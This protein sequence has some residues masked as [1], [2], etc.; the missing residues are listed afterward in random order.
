M[1]IDLWFIQL[2]LSSSHCISNDKLFKQC[3]VLCCLSSS[4]VCGVPG[5]K[6]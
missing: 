6:A 2:P 1:I 4:V 5:N 3:L